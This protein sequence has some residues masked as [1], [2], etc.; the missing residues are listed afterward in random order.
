MSGCRGRGLVL[1]PGARSLV[2]AALGAARAAAEY[3]QRER[4]PLSPHPGV[5]AGKHELLL[6]GAERVAAATLGV[7]SRGVGVEAAEGRRRGAR[8]RAAASGA[9]LPLPGRSERWTPGS[10][11]A[12]SGR[13]WPRIADLPGSRQVWRRWVRAGAT[14]WGGTLP[15]PG[16]LGGS[17]PAPTGSA[18]VEQGG[19][20]VW[21]LDKDRTGPTAHL[22]EEAQTPSQ[23]VTVTLAVHPW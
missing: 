9:L 2:S 8:V 6:V 4:Q 22:A 12:P 11:A 10:Q 23:R 15:G 16:A 5:R 18:S 14:R 13:G 17:S 7:H 3:L 1:T 21:D 20:Q 19:F